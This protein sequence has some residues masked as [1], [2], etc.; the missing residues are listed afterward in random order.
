MATFEALQSSWSNLDETLSDQCSGTDGNVGSHCT[1]A[2]G[3]HAQISARV[4]DW[5][6]LPANDGR[7]DSVIAALDSARQQLSGASNDPGPMLGALA[8]ANNAM[9]MVEALLDG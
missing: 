1:S 2:L 6:A 3:R 8:S 9:S 4:A 5:N 7:Y